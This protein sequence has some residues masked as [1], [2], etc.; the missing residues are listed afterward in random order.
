MM[1]VKLVKGQKALGHAWGR[2]EESELSFFLATAYVL[3]R[4]NTNIEMP[5]TMKQVLNAW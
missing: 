5:S 3:W 2:G 1:I 4:G